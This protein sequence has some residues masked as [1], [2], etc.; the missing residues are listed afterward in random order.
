MPITSLIKAD[1]QLQLFGSE[2][3]DASFFA[4]EELGQTPQFTGARL[5]ANNPDTYRAVVAL[6]AEGLGA[7][8]IGKIL[9]VSPNT[10]LAV[11]AR[12][13][14]NIDIEK[15]RLANLSSAA[16][17]MCVEGIIEMLSDPEQV[18]KMSIKDK[19]IVF[20]I[21][22]EKAELLSGSPTAR[23]QTVSA[24]SDV[25]V[26]EYMCWL[27]TEY[28]RRIG[29][30]TGKDDQRAPAVAKMIEAEVLE[31][32]APAAIEAE[33]LPANAPMEDTDQKKIVDPGAKCSVGKMTH[34]Q[35]ETPVNIDRNEG[36]Q[37]AAGLITPSD[38]ENSKATV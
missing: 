38:L 8:R 18:K 27:K 22:A 2:H 20:G 19:G 23:L 17:R 11:R 36:A 31:T 1:N 10:V 34:R 3:M 6:S 35:D 16:A 4:A 5:F 37:K 32:P 29:L 28:E 15:R 25:E 24:P 12:E 26:V 33:I 21:L 7:I 30:K 14:E 9:H 13:P